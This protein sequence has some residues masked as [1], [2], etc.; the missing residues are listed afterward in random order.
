MIL[1]PHLY[2]L[3]QSMVV[4]WWALSPPSY[5]PK[6]FPTTFS[7]NSGCNSLYLPTSHVIRVSYMY[8]YILYI[9]IYIQSAEY[10][11]TLSA[12]QLVEYI[13][14]GGSIHVT[15]EVIYIYVTANT[16]KMYFILCKLYTQYKCDFDAGLWENIY[17]WRYITFISN[18]LLYL[19]QLSLALLLVPYIYI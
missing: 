7:F 11:S 4:T 8:I 9:C 5:P 16:Y 2:Q 17:M 6:I 18:C 10:I 14:K 3:K 15:D 13:Q 19:L 12:S 1:H